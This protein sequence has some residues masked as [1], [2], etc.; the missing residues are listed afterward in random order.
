MCGRYSLIAVEKIASAFPRFRSGVLSRTRP[1]PRFNVAPSQEVLGVRNDGDEEIDVLRWGLRGRINV[2][3][4]TLAASRW[5]VARRCVL[6][7]DGFYEWRAGTPVYYTLRSGEPFALAGIWERDGQA[8]P[9]CAIATCEP[10]ELVGAVHDRMPAILASGALEMWLAPE[11]LPAPAAAALLQPFDAAA[12]QGCDVSRRVN[13]ARYD[14][15]DI[16]TA[17]D[18][19]QQG[20]SF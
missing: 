20:F 12:M 9:M 7:A 5:P 4:E 8:A 3:G 11:P 2:R 10:N 19:V 18:P 14:A 13:D 17:R 6:F 15:P 1:V 16:L